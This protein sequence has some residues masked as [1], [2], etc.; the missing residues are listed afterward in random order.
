MCRNHV[1]L[2]ARAMAIKSEPSE[3]GSDGRGRVEIFEESDDLAAP[4]IPDVD[5]GRHEGLAG[6]SVAERAFRD[7]HHA[8]AL[9]DHSLDVEE[10]QLPVFPE[11]L[12]IAAH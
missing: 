10:N 6:A 3:G 11:I 8:I 5:L 1:F 7:N 4:E 12:E 9:G 2:V